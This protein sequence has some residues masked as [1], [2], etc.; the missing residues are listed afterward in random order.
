MFRRSS[1]IAL[2]CLACAAEQPRPERHPDPSAIPLRRHVSEPRYLLSTADVLFA[3]YEDGTLAA[4]DQK[5][6]TPLRVTKFA[7]GTAAGSIALAGGWLYAVRPFAKDVAVLEP[8]TLELAATV[9]VKND[10]FLCASSDRG[11]LYFIS[12]GDPA[13]MILRAD[14]HAILDR[15]PLPETGRGAGSC[16]ESA[17]GRYLYLAIQ[18]GSPPKDPRG[19]PLPTETGFIAQYDLQERRYVAYVPAGARKLDD[20]VPM[21]MVFSEDGATLFVGMFQSDAGI[22]AISVPQMAPAGNIA[23]AAQNG[24][25]AEL[26]PLALA[27]ANGKLFAYVRRLGQLA[28]LDAAT[29]KPIEL[30]PVYG[31]GTGHP[32]LTFTREDLVVAS[33]SLNWIPLGRL[34]R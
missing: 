29:R 34:P 15:I 16:L 3:S 9:P 28:V 31:D 6:R 19:N 11:R 13:W 7:A 1:S 25:A 12:N 23:F 4:F 33:G 14:T 10:G 21:A 17:D 2:L 24:S 18:R 5:T 22:Y 20:A 30:L 8:S 32:G 26:D 27:V